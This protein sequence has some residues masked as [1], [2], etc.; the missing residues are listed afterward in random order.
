MTEIERILKEVEEM[1]K[2]GDGR[3]S[4]Q[5]GGSAASSS[6]DMAETK[7]IL[8]E[9]KEKDRRYSKPEA[10][11]RAT[12]QQKTES[13]MDDITREEPEARSAIDRYKAVEDAKYYAQMNRRGAER[14][15]DAML[16]RGRS[17]YERSS[18][19]WRASYDKGPQA[20]Q[21]VAA[22]TPE[23]AARNRNYW[24]EAAKQAAQFGDQARYNMAMKNVAKFQD[25][26]YNLQMEENER[27]REEYEKNL[28]ALRQSNPA[29]YYALTKSDDEIDRMIAYFDYE[30][31]NNAGRSGYGVTRTPEEEARYLNNLR[32]ARFA[33]ESDAERA[34]YIRAEQ[35]RY[36]AASKSYENRRTVMD[37]TTGRT[38]RTVADDPHWVEYF[39]RTPEEQAEYINNLRRAR[40]AGESG[41][42]RE[43][44][45]QAEQNRYAEQLRNY[46]NGPDYNSNL[47]TDM[48]N[49]ESN[50]KSLELAK[51]IHELERADKSPANIEAGRAALREQQGRLLTENKYYYDKKTMSRLATGAGPADSKDYQ[52]MIDK[53]WVLY[54]DFYELPEDQ[55]NNVYAVAAT[56]PEKAVS[57]A[58][59]YLKLAEDEHYQKIHDWVNKDSGWQFGRRALGM[60]GGAAAKLASGL[61]PYGT[62]GQGM[63]K[64]GNALISGGAASASRNG[65]FGIEFLGGDESGIS[66]DV[67]FI[68]KGQAG[69]TYQV[70]ASVLQSVAT[71]VPA[72]IA[73]NYSAA[74]SKVAET[75][76]LVLMGSS[77]AADDYTECIDRGMTVDQARLHATAAG[78]AEAAFERISLENLIHPELTTNAL[79]RWLQQAGIEAS[80]EVV[81]SIANRISDELLTDIYGV[82]SDVDRRTR[83]LVADGLSYNAARDKAKNEWITEV[84]QDGMS[85]FLSGLIMGGG[86]EV[87]RGVETFRLNRAS[88]NTQTPTTF[89]QQEAA[90]DSSRADS[91]FLEDGSKPEISTHSPVEEATIKEYRQSINPE[92]KEAAEQRLHN[93]SSDFKRITISKVSDRQAGDATRLLG[94]AYSGYVNAINSN[95]IQHTINRHGPNGVADHS[96]SSMD[97]L[98][99]VGYVLDNYDSVE[100]ATEGEDEVDVSAEFRDKNNRPAPML[101]YSKRVDGTYYVVQAVPDS[102]WKKM[103][104]VSAYMKNADSV[105]QALD[106][107]SPLATSETSHASPLSAEDSIAQQSK[108]VKGEDQD[109]LRRQL[110]AGDDLGLAEGLGRVGVEQVNRGQAV[111]GTQTENGVQN[112]VN[113]QGGLNIGTVQQAAENGGYSQRETGRSAG[114]DAEAGQVSLPAG[115]RGVY[116]RNQAWG[117][118]Q[119][120]RREGRGRE[121]QSVIRQRQQAAADNPLVSPADEGVPMGAEDQTVRI[122]SE[123]D[124]DAE[125]KSG[126]E[127]AYANGIKKV[128][129]YVGLLQVEADGERCSVN[130]C[131]NKDT[132]ELFV[133]ADSSR[134]SISEIIEHEVGHLKTNAAKVRAFMEAVKSTYKETA[135]SKLYETY[136]Q[137]YADVTGDYAGMTEAEKELYIWEE[138]Q[139]DAAAF[140]NKFGARASAYNAEA[141]QTLESNLTTEETIGSNY[142]FEGGRYSN[143]E[144]S[145]A[146]DRTNGPGNNRVSDDRVNNPYDGKDLSTDRSVYT[147]SFLTQQEAMQEVAMPEVS[148]VL[149][150]NGEIDNHRVIQLGLKNAEAVGSVSGGKAYVQNRYTKKE[151][152]VDADSIRHGLNGDLRRHMTNAR[153]GSVIGEV[154]QNAIPLNALHNSGKDVTGTYVMGC[155]VTDSLGRE[156]VAI[157]TVEERTNDVVGLQIEDA[158]HAVSGRQK[159]AGGRTRSP[160]GVYPSSTAAI[161]IADFLNIVNSTHQSLLSNDVL[162]KINASKNP[163]GY[164]TSRAKFSAEGDEIAVDWAGNR[165]EDAAVEQAIA[166]ENGSMDFKDQPTGPRIVETTQDGKT[167]YDDG[168]EL[169]EGLG[170]VGEVSQEDYRPAQDRAR[171]RLTQGLTDAVNTVRGRNGKG[172]KVDDVYS[173]AE[174]I[175]D[176]MEAN[177]ARV[178]RDNRPSVTRNPLTEDKINNISK[179]YPDKI[180]DNRTAWENLSITYGEE[181]L[182]K[183][184]FRYEEGGP[185]ETGRKKKQKVQDMK[186]SKPYGPPRPE[187]MTSALNS[188]GVKVQGSVGDY[189]LVKQMLANDKSA[190]SVQREVQR[191]E[192]RLGRGVDSKIF[193]KEK[194]FAAGIAAGLYS[195][196]DVPATFDS[197]R[198]MELADYYA[199]ERATRNEMIRQRRSQIRQDLNHQMSELFKNSDDGKA[200]SMIVLN[201]R[202]PERNMRHIFGDELG[203]QINEA[204]FYPTQA[205]EAERL[206]FIN[207]MHDEVRTFTDKNG[208]QSKLNKAERA[209]AQALL[210]GK[211]FEQLMAAAEETNQ[212]KQIEEIVEAIRKGKVDDVKVQNAVEAYKGLYNQ[213]YEAINDFLVAHGYEPIGFI[214]NYAPHMQSEET[215]TLLQ[216]AFQ[217][218]GMNAGVTELPASIAGLTADFKPSKRWNPHF[219]QREG[220]LTKYDVAEGFEEYIEYISDIFYHMDDTMRV[221]EA[222]KYFRETYAPEEI[223]AEIERVKALQDASSEEK[224]ELLRDA[225]EVGKDTVLS[226]SDLEN[227]F[228][229]YLEKLYDRVDKTTKHSNLTIWLDNYANLLAGKQSM[230]DRGQEYSIG[231]RAANWANRLVRTFAQSKVAGSLSS[232][233]NQ[234]A[235]IPMIYSELGTRWTVAAI[236]DIMTGKLRRAAWWQQSDFLTGKHG[237]DYLVTTPGQMVMTSLFKLSELMDGFVST[238][239]VRGKYLEQIKAGKSHE[240][241]LKIA[242]RFGQSIMG[243]RAKGSRPNAYAGK[244]LISQAVHIFQV[245]AM[246][247]W[248]HL[249][250]DL[251]RDFREIARTKGKG[252]AALSLAGVIVKMLLAGF[253]INRLDDE[254]YGGTPAQFDLLGLSA[255]FIASGEGL[256]TNEWLRTVI[257]NGLEKIT[258]KRIFDTDPD[259]IGDDDFNW[260]AAFEDTAY[261]I[262]NDVPFIRNLSG[263]AG[264]GDQTMPMPDLYNKGKNIVNAAEKHGVFSRDTGK[265][266]MQAATELIPGGNQINKAWQGVEAVLR[267]GDFSGYG[268]NEKLKYPLDESAI[269]ALRAIFFG[270]YA[271][272]ESD[273][274][275]ASGDTM[276]SE[277]YTQVWKDLTG[278]GIKRQ[279]AYK[280]IQDIRDIAGDETISTFER[281][282][283]KRDLIAKLPWSDDQKAKLYSGMI[284]SS[285]DDEIQALADVGLGFNDFLDVQS[286]YSKI[287]DEYEKANQ[288]ATALAR[289]VNQQS[290]SPEQ[291]AAINENFKYW[292][293]FPAQ[294]GKYEDFVEAGLSDDDASDLHNALSNL[295]PEDG[296]DQV[297]NLQK[298][299]AVVNAGLNEQNTMLALEK[300]MTE[301]EYL[302]LSVGNE[303]GLSPVTYVDFKEMLPKFDDDKNGSYTQKEVEKALKSMNSLTNKQKAILWQIVDKRWKAENNPFNKDV[304]GKVYNDLNG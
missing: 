148:E 40:F 260:S 180:I 263:I 211:T 17:G 198:V 75:I 228:D 268:S 16:E 254:L 223:K 221:R 31:K 67:P 120:T 129:M 43:A 248:E 66:S 87:M 126:A 238:I 93:P 214:Q 235:Q 26:Q 153:I 99:R 281:G 178:N 107:P 191:A 141:T 252:K 115:N 71:A 194:N 102:K 3:T 57:L 230:A 282:Q 150:A 189:S 229:N 36:Q 259:E 295:Q 293:Q 131:I 288:K 68:G 122:W 83:E 138:I 240:E 79:K 101:K 50:I 100:V 258:G 103:W 177:G 9:I 202:T 155:Y 82:E 119:E 106:V 64:A 24:A 262:T 149:D 204:I 5:T 255:N 245:E 74:A 219:L 247:S 199:A 242:D 166:S 237:V 85:G 151:L 164:Y 134:E 261:N 54:P 170:R 61:D 218:L 154:V 301:G 253:V 55:Q 110:A 23:R 280:A 243:S 162:S 203:E 220:D 231:R 294:A 222:A 97:D 90:T 121:Q 283:Q 244:G 207:R 297:S 269:S 182:R 18:D 216:K 174:Y 236:K 205:N 266:A 181:T 111:T 165:E 241:A 135:W 14:A 232:V 296:K 185:E 96:M 21:P 272:K 117:V 95:G 25:D 125:A 29:E 284:S 167:A 127:Y 195:S 209:V 51:S 104:V 8:K 156:Y 171:D 239:A 201:E 76:G 7:R 217:H 213:L 15:N 246:N 145:A 30:N 234:G 116:G 168:L 143:R 298:Y 72:I 109:L 98:A 112:A 160:Q 285:K 70:G 139:C 19:Q 140:T 113:E 186:E 42:E 291:R 84:I 4:T 300:V 271:T 44:Y 206:R 114:T 86:S 124:W 108:T 287:D 169:A 10:N 278:S 227:A 105:T 27:Q 279:D 299:R 304:G 172:T 22:E 161:S 132:G 270:K 208:K 52:E 56:D 33:G 302:K 158:V 157:I 73:G 12:L 128:T 257:D 59:H 163:N 159:K 32:R 188:L 6:S 60:V 35:E 267:G 276:L 290:Y 58:Q 274:Y 292:M 34:A 187:P 256:T 147:Y 80:E 133:R 136:E 2:A 200:S 130:G 69:L 89:L 20:S 233:L 265:A 286:A 142:R 47:A 78:V 249:S 303:Y 1:R 63:S 77:A 62:M 251:P 45:I 146:T 224:L 137:R 92:L 210:E 144:T 184:G 277:K 65:L 183:A 175:A 179:V 173:P 193:A 11:R 197:E 28:E 226:E 176:S 225:K 264:W 273:A 212:F 41:E 53:G 39:D 152:R 192:R 275:Y 38:L 49:A 123:E 13:W 289:W 91:L 190:K 48:I 88:R 196:A 94:G 118:S 37:D 250:Q 215:Q 81:T 46:Q